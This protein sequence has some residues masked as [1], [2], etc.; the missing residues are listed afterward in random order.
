M[1]RETLVYVLIFAPLAALLFPFIK[2]AA[3]RTAIICAVSVTLIASSITVALGGPFIHSAESI[4]G[5]Q[6]GLVAS[7]LDYALLAYFLYLGAVRK[8]PLVILLALAQAV[9]LVYLET[10]AKVEPVT[11]AVFRVD[12]LV[13]AMCLVVSIV[14]SVIVMFAIP[15]MADH[16]KHH[17]ELPKRSPRFF[18]WLVLFLGAMNGL[19][20]SDNLFIVY[21]FWEITTLC[22]VQLIRHDETEIAV[23]NAY[24]ALWMNLIGGTAFAWAIFLLAT[25]GQPLSIMQLIAAPRPTHVAVLL[26]VALLCLAGFTKAAQLPFQGW[27]LGAMVAPTPVSS[28][29]HSSTMVKAGVYLLLRFAPVYAGTAL[30]SVVTLIGGFTFAAAAML[31]ISQT[32]GKRVLAYSTISNLGLIVTCAG[33]NT[34]TAVSVGV[35]LILFHALSKAL[36]FMTTGTIE[37]KID[38]RIIE[39]MRG[40]I[41]YMPF[42]TTVAIIG[43]LSM[44]LPPFGMLLAKWAALEAAASAPEVMVLVV[45]G[46]TFTIVFWTKWMGRMLGTRPTAQKPKLESLNILYRLPLGALCCMVIALS[47]AVTLVISNLVGPAVEAYYAPT[48]Y[49]IFDL[50]LESGVGM[51]PIVVVTTVIGLSVGIPALLLKNRPG[52]P[53]TVYL[54]GEQA[55]DE[56]TL[57]F[58]SADDQPSEVT[59]GFYYFDKYFGEGTHNRWL[60]AVAIVL[61]VATVA[62]GM[63]H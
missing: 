51:F 17:P 52:E 41:S 33:L 31:A 26:P 38:S 49:Q 34:P 62:T 23:T 3:A 7:V 19:L 28:L 25:Q 43:M 2:N 15:Y 40:L 30:S 63:V 21:L 24:R 35:M 29:L 32:D 20:L 10:V 12:W 60:N 54:C 53:N 4:G 22:C 18:M 13:I 58:V 56:Q 61:M 1:T 44:Y 39:D 55:A 48:Q 14:G 46:S 16:E 45:M 42:T 9:P 59:V 36:L 57:A 47:L 37:V 27:L 5:V 50:G 6:W 8:S 11:G